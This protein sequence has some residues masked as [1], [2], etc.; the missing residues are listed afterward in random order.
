[1]DCSLPG[2]SVYW[3]L[4]VRILE[5]VA[6]SSLGDLP[7]PGIGP[8]FP[9]LQADSLSSEPPGKPKD[10]GVGSLSLLQ[11]LFLTQESKQ[12][13]LH[14]RWILYQLSYQGSLKCM[15]VSHITVFYIMQ[16]CHTPRNLGVILHSFLT[17]SNV[18]FPKSVLYLPSLLLLS[19]LGLGFHH[20]LNS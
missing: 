8:R 5:W 2:S 19:R 1:M 6:V 16:Y 18:F 20:L 17:S 15:K 10:T 14:F 7:N 4:Q 13:L 3:I 12:S 11:R 9:A